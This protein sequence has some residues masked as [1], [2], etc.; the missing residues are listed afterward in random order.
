M[1][2]KKQI[3]LPRSSFALANDEDVFINLQL[4]KTFSDI[5][6]EKINNVFNITEQYNK[7]RQASLKFCIYGLVESRFGNTGNLILDIEES[8]G[9]TFHLPK[10]SSD[11]ISN[12]KISIKTFE[13]TLDSNGMSR[14]L[15]GKTKSAYSFLFEIDRNELIAQDELI[16]SNGGIPKTR[17]VNFS[18]IDT[19]KNV[20]F[21]KNIPYL[22]YDLEGNI[23]NFGTQTSDIDEEG[24]TIELNNDFDFFYDRHWIRNYFD[25]PAPSFV[26][27]PEKSIDI[28]EN[29]PSGITEIEIA[30][31]QKSPFGLEEAVVTIGSN[32]TINNPNQDFVFTT[33][34]IKWNVGEQYK[35]FN[36][37]VLDDKYVESTESLILKVSS[38]KNCVA[39]SQKETELNI[40]IIDDDIPSYIRFLSGETTI[41]SNASA[42]TV[43][44]IFDKPLEVPNQ[45][46]TMYFTPNT[47][48]VL[49]KDFILDIN[50]PSA[51]ELIINFNQGDISG[52]T[53]IGIIDNDIYNLDK[54]IELAFKDMSQNIALSNVGAVPKVG[55]VFTAIITE[56]IITQFASFMF[57]NNPDKKIGAIRAYRNPDNYNQYYYNNDEEKGFKPALDYDITITNEGDDVIYENV[58]IKKGSTLVKTISVTGQ[59]TTDIV[60]DLP[61]NYS[62]DKINRKYKKCKYDF[63]IKSNEK[64]ATFQSNFI[65][66]GYVENRFYDSIY[67]NAEK[68]AGPSGSTK[69][70]LTTKLTKFYLNYASSLSSCTVD[71]FF[72]NNTAY[73]NN[74]VFIGHN[75][76]F[77]IG[78]N[79]NPNSPDSKTTVTFEDSKL[80]SFC[81]QY[82]PFAFEKLPSPPYKFQYINLKFRNIY[83]QSSAFVNGY[84]KLKIDYSG[85][86]GN[87]G[88]FPWS[89]ASINTRQAITLSVLNNGEVP[90]D[91]LSL[92]PSLNPNNS[93]QINNVISL[94]SST[95]NSTTVAPGDKFYIR[96]FDKELNDLS[97][98]LPANESYIKSKSAFTFAN[99]LITVENVIYYNSSG[100]TSGNPLSFQFEQTNTLDTGPLSATPQYYIVSEYKDMN[101]PY[102]MGSYN[103]P[104]N[105]GGGPL[106]PATFVDDCSSTNFN[107]VGKTDLAI[108]GL[109]LVNS[110]SSFKRGYFVEPNNDLQLTC[111]AQ[112]Y[113][114]IPYKKLTP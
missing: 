9:L 63:T 52:S 36:F 6:N 28:P 70:F 54:K 14:N 15:Y 71:S 50:N 1:N 91:I 95:T 84:N 82:Y 8:N 46:V 112:N 17:T 57:V 45:K 24:N 5:K 10:I 47:N 88:F 56:S 76:S 114:R 106:P 35:K 111:V 61:A 94:T 79:T 107:L 77:T 74:L 2:I 87:V 29:I 4:N 75:S 55:P 96:G 67:I 48:A 39:K 19:E 34:T 92:N 113:S 69:Y 99:Y 33:E 81:S 66:Y 65:D 51:T 103:Q 108:R 100:Q 23:V 41:K 38:F 101:V 49:G 86:L 18:I 97:L 58:L 43:S 31:D 20:F 27:F 73:T 7:E 22:F 85:N 32:S 64:F 59:P 68:D 104:Y 89:A 80:P 93:T 90:V 25:F 40:N 30:I 16:R 110:N 42:L 26:F 53:T 62:F 78:I 21:I 3:L 13:L 12:K 83:P 105:F 102:V 37:N 60:I 109:L 98:I 72:I 11:N 44:Y